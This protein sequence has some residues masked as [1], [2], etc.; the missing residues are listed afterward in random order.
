MDNTVLP[1]WKKPGMTSYDVVRIIKN[2]NKKFKVGHCGTLDPFAEGVLLVCT[3]KETKNITT[4]MCYK[5]EYNATI[6]LGSETDTLDCTGSIIKSNK[7]PKLT[8]D[9]I[10][11]TLDEFKGSYLQTPPYY[12]ALRFKGIRLYKYARKGI[13]IKKKP[14]KVFIEDL[15]LIDFKNNQISIYVKCEKGTYIR[16]IARDIAYKLKTYG[17]VIKLS[18]IAIGPFNQDNSYTINT[19]DTCLS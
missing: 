18:R 6:L 3:G 16:S 8:T 2:K 7:C 5:K 11:K 19:L 1:I 14:R 9:K 15:K 12:S 17:H 13:Y 4:L 10:N